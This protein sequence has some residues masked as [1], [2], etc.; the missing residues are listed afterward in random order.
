MKVRFSEQ[1]SRD[2]ESI[3]DFI[4]HDNPRRAITFVA[5]IREAC[6]RLTDAPRGYA[7]IEH[8]GVTSEE[9]SIGLI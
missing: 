5:E 7:L 1:A 3:A 2:L 8:P 6:L 9:L 4:A